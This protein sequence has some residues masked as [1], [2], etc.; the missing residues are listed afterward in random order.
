[1]MG[2]G[3]TVC[4]ARGVGPLGKFTLDS[5]RPNNH[6]RMLGVKRFI[7]SLV[8]TVAGQARESRASPASP[9]TVSAF[10]QSSGGA[11]YTVTLTIGARGPWAWE[12]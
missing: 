3:L 9:E 12:Q 2:G 6:N 7:P 11:L 10:R 4:L 1:M 8:L 5:G